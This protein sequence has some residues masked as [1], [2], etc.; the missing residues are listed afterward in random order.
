MAFPSEHFGATQKRKWYK[1]RWNNKANPHLAGKVDLLADDVYAK[2]K[3]CVD[4]I[5]TVETDTCTGGVPL[6]F[7]KWGEEKINEWIKTNR[8]K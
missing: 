2:Q 3:N 7:G 6:G 8:C 5:E 1:V 4:L